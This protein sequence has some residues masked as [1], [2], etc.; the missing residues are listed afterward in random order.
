MIDPITR[1]LQFPIV[2]S[3]LAGCSNLPFRLLSRRRGLEFCYF[4]MMSVN[5]L[6]N[7]RNK[8]LRLLKTVVEDSPIGVQLL[9]SDPANMA[10]AAEIMAELGFKYMDLNLGCPVRKIVSQ[11]AGSALLAAPKKAEEIFNT[12]VRAVPSIPVTVKIRKGFKDDSGLEALAVARAAEDSGIAAITVH[13]R[14]QKQGYA[15]KADWD[16]IA[17][18]KAAVK[19]PVIGNG[20]IFSAT[21]AL[22]MKETTHCDGVMIGRGSLGNPWIFR[23]IRSLLVDGKLVDPPTGEEKLKTVLEHLELELK[24]EGEL[25]A[26]LHM[27]KVGS[28]YIFGLPNAAS[29]RRRLFATNTRDEVRALLLEALSP[30][31]AVGLIS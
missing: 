10:K 16:V 27:R 6:L 7:S 15:G 28:W 12:V 20:D 8:S 30:L 21:D 29:L 11:G 17:Q 13:G 23:E 22:K 19:I 25:K 1:K 26:L 14:T 4:E 18:V 24:Y 2:Q 9:G 5:G 31:P 3:P